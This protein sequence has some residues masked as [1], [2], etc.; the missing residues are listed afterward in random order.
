MHP[1]KFLFD[2]GVLVTL[3][4]DD[5]AFFNIELIDEYW[6]MYKYLNFSLKD[7]KQLIING[8]QSSFIKEKDKKKYIN[9]VKTEWEKNIN[10]LT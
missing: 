7:I 5:P 9:K 1:I 10:L 3:N 2:K 6:N 4:T 8:F